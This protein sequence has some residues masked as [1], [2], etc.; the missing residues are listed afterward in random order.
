MQM[1]L[2]LPLVFGLLAIHQSIILS[3]YKIDYQSHGFA[4]I[5]ALVFAKVM[6]VAEDLRLGDRFDDKPLIY[7]ILFKSL[8]F[9]IILICFHIVEA[10]PCGN[11]AWTKRCRELFQY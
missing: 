4:V 10:C 8:L 11:V 2:Y 6:L 7:P 9:A 3:R 5:N 1:F